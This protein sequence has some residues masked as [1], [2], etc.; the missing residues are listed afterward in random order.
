[1]I[2]LFDAVD[3]GDFYYPE[4]D[5]S[6][7]IKIKKFYKLNVGLIPDLYESEYINENSNVFVLDI[8]LVNMSK[9]SIHSSALVG[10]ISLIDKDGYEF[11]ANNDSFLSLN[12]K[13]AKKMGFY[14][15]FCND[16]N[17]LIEVDGAITFILPDGHGFDDVG[18]KLKSRVISGYEIT[19]N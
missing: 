7:K 13:Y 11:S 5:D 9:K 18:M 1:M 2:S 19:P 16:F 15:F 8:T 14:V 17:P 3:S 4:C 10:K 6:V 12:W